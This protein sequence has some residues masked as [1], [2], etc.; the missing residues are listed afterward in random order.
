MRSKTARPKQVRR[1]SKKAGLPPGTLVHVGDR[2][3]E[4]VRVTYLDYD[5]NTVE[6]KQVVGSNPISSI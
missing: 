1:R 4:S 6:K 2:K 3:V 5:E